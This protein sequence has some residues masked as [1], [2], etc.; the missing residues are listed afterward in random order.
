[1]FV[2]SGDFIAGNVSS[3]TIEK[4]SWSAPSLRGSIRRSV[5]NPG[6]ISNDLSDYGGVTGTDYT[7]NVYEKNLERVVFLL[8]YVE[9]DPDVRITSPSGK[10]YSELE[11]NI[12]TVLYEN[13]IA[14]IIHNPEQGTWQLRVENVEEE[15]YSL[16]VLGTGR[17]PSLVI[18]E[19]DFLTELVQDEFVLRGQAEKGYNSIIVKARENR[20]KPGLELGVFPVESDGS[21]EALVPVEDIADGEY[22]ISVELVT[23]GEFTAPTAYA[24]GKIRVDRSGLPLLEPEPVRLAETDRGTVVLRWENNN[25]ARTA[26]YNIKIVNKTTGSENTIYAGNITSF[27]LPGFDAGE[28]IS[29]QVAAIDSSRQESAYSAPVGIITGGKRPAINRPLILDELFG[30]EGVSGGLVE[31]SITVSIEEYEESYEASG[32]ILARRRKAE[33]NAPGTP[34]FTGPVKIEQKTVNIPW[35]LSLPADTVPGVYAYPCEAVNEANGEL[36]APFILEVQVRWP[37]P[38]IYSVNP[39]KFNGTEEQLITLYGNGFIPGTKVMFGGSELVLNPDRDEWSTSVMEAVLPAQKQGGIYSLAVIGPGGKSAS[40]EITILLPDWYAELYGRTVETVPGGNADYWLGV[41]GIEGFNGSASFTVIEKPETLDITLPLIPAGSIGNIRIHVRSGTVPG[42]Y[43]S[44]ISGGEGKNFELITVVCENTP[45]PR[46]TA[47]SPPHGYPLS[48]VSLYGSSLGSGGDLYLNNIRADI[49]FWSNSKITFTVPENGESG[50]VRVI[51]GTENGNMESNA[52][53]FT[54]RKRGFSLRPETSRLEMSAGEKRKLALFLTGYSDV[55][56]LRVETGGAPLSAVLNLPSA[57]PNAALELEIGV[58]ANNG[59]YVNGSWKIRI[60][61]NSGNYQAET[62]I[63]IHV[64]DAPELL[65]RVLPDGL[66]EVSYYEKLTLKSGDEKVEYRVAGGELPPGLELS[67][68]GEIRGKPR[69]TGRY[70]AEI[71]LTDSVG[72]KGNGTVVITIREESWAQAGKDGGKSRSAN[73]EMPAG[74][75]VLF[76][77]Q[78]SMVPDYILAAEEK[79]ILVSKNGIAVIRASNGRTDW[80]LAGNYQQV[81]YAGGKLYALTSQGVLETRELD[82]GILLWSREGIRS[83]SSDG[84]LVLAKTDDACLFLDATLGFLRERKEKEH[85]DTSSVI[86]MNHEA[87]EIKG[88]RVTAVHGKEAFLEFNHGILAAAADSMGMALVT[89]NSLIILDRKLGEVARIERA[90]SGTVEL[91]LNADTVFVSEKG[92]VC[93]YGRDKADLIHEWPL[94]GEAT[95]GIAAGKGSLVIMESERLTVMN[96]FNGNVLWQENESYR[97]FALYREKIYT[98]GSEGTIRVYGGSINPRGP[99]TEIVLE[100]ASP[101]GINGWYITTP[102]LRITSVDRETFTASV[103]AWLDGEELED[104]ES[105]IPLPDGEHQISAYGMD[106]HGVRSPIERLQVKV[107]TAP[108]KSEYIL[109]GEEPENG[110]YGGPVELEIE[111]WD[112][113]SGLER[114]WTNNG[115]YDGPVSFNSQG[116]HNFSWYAIDRAGNK[117]ETHQHTIRVDYE[118]PYTDAEILLDRGTGELSLRAEDSVSGV[119]MIEYRLNGGAA[120]IYRERIFL[121]EGSYRLEY[122][123]ADRAGNYSEWRTAEFT[124]QPLWAEASLIADVSIGGIKRAVVTNLRNGMPILR[125]DGKKPEPDRSSPAALVNLPSYVMGAE[126][127]IWEPEDVSAGEENAGKER[128]IRFRTAKD[129]VAYLFLPEGKEAPASWSPVRE[130]A[131]INQTW[132]A[133]GV[134]VYMKRLAGENRVEIPVT[135]SGRL[136]P[137]VAIQERGS[138]SADIVIRKNGDRE[139]K[140]GDPGNV[141]MPVIERAEFIEEYEA[142]TD[143]LLDGRP[144]PWRYSRRLPLIKKWYVSYRT[145]WLP[146]EGNCWTIPED[147]EPGY[148]RFRVELVTPDGQVEYRTEKN[149]VVIKGKIQE[150]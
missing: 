88:N 129:V 38:E 75:D 51:T 61:G 120:E 2:G 114:I 44:V 128:I 86:W 27:T 45:A 76:T 41:T 20:D 60:V 69:H 92:L 111:A 16:S 66:A 124:I 29:F 125:E 4:P 43:R 116:V 104:P 85:D 107:D 72:R 70:Q 36:N 147:T 71:A 137:L 19:P 115:N 134:S 28:E 48:E 55:V 148:I 87:Y 90:F 53:S 68:D 32:Y 11:G 46:L 59:V 83:F 58:N 79:V 126:Y 30:A 40:F 117:E 109:S 103:M 12:E 3:F 133:G 131:M 42:T 141:D 62:E 143:L 31:G 127:I 105:E 35:R 77:M 80:N 119:E 15:T 130:D 78:A 50:I 67:V 106:S 139:G 73:T 23:G 118:K 136:P 102:S 138:V 64:A 93:G 81:M 95:A 33:T 100:P 145:E 25:G 34:H 96:C 22:V 39:A 1:M 10:E 140:A 108:P 24:P 74:N 123:A 110:W 7:V 57:I 13:L 101:D 18:T 21:F 63:S 144:S 113:L 142:G 49:L 56:N 135:G 84:T 149:I 89:E 112:D 9:G 99:E 54:V 150:E 65:K 52:L 17:M 14:F 132:Y 97:Q 6:I 146:L 8:A 94:G 5:S 98:S 91:A 47:A 37:D 82:L 121:D 122:R 26:G